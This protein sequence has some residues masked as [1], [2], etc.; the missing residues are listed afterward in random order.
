MES[1][2]GST[3]RPSERSVIEIET[4]ACCFIL[5]FWSLRRSGVDG[6]GKLFTLGQIFN[7]TLNAML[8]SRSSD[9][10]TH[11]RESI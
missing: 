8:L 2:I 1:I 3:S 9:G 10:C 5:F 11:E 4:D 7:P 6:R